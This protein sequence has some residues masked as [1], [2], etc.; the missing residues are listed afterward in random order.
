MRARTVY[1]CTQIEMLN[2]FLTEMLLHLC[3]FAEHYRSALVQRSARSN[4]RSV[5]SFLNSSA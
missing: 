4:I 5:V 1:V 2:L 3:V